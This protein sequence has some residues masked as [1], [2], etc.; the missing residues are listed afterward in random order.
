[1]GASLELMKLT[2]YTDEEFQTPL[3]GQ[4][5]TVMIN[6]DSI[7][8]S[9]S[10]EYN[11]QQPPDTSSPSQKYKNTP[12]EK[13]SF[14]IVIDCTGIVDSTRTSMATEISSLETICYTYN[15]KIHRP[16]FVKVQWGKDISFNG[17]LTSFDTSYT[18]FRPDG[19]PLRAKISLSFSQYISVSTVTKI[20]A[21]SSPDLT[22]MVT[23]VQDVNLPQLCTKVWNDYS[24]YIQ[25]ARYNG[26]NKFR[27]L[28][29]GT[30]L[31]FPPII[32]STS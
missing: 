4:P 1:M 25:V 7:K 2:G 30:K 26:L 10:V 24:F 13:L 21:P 11:E 9:R 20:D 3:S 19:S 14:D 18:L 27:N 32:Q 17:V 8:W 22:H 29:S 16:N 5:Y 31:I 15:G 23:V 28:K 6:P 12:S